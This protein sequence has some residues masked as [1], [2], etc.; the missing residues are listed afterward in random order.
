MRYVPAFLRE[1]MAYEDLMSVN[2][3]KLL[4]MGLKM[5]PRKRVLHNFALR[6]R[7]SWTEEVDVTSKE[8]VTSWPCALGI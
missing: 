5:G 4:S 7:K 8:W 2:E 3:A 6:T 1:E